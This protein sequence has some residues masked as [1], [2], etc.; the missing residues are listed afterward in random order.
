MT[1][2][3]QSAQYELRFWL[4]VL[5]DHLLFIRTGLSPDE[6]EEINT[7]AGL[8]DAWTA[9][10]EDLPGCVDPSAMAGFAGRA[11]EFTEQVRAYKLHLLRRKLT[12]QI[13]FSLTPTF[14][15]H[16]VNEV[17]EAQRVL[18]SLSA[19]QP[20]A[21]VHPLHHDM[22]WLLDASGHASVLHGMTDPAERTVLEKTSAFTA[23]FDAFYLKAME[24]AGYLRTRAAYFPALTRL[25]K[26]VNLEMNVFRL[27][28][29]ELEEL[30]LSDQLLRG[31]LPLLPDHMA[32]EECY[33]LNQLARSGAV[34]NPECDPSGV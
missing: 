15:N 14:V 31:F 20:P 33:Y 24:L 12:D 11:Q 29:R 1:N 6:T 2:Y 28:L 19:G 25:H 23:T 3:V 26:D 4:P 16:M 30:A 27:F 18:D 10:A 32:R 13:Q 8:L 22:L 9:V 17:D 7:N 34:P 5:R 21:P